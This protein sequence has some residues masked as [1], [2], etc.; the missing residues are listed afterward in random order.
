MLLFRGSPCRAAVN[1]RFQI[2]NLVPVLSLLGG[3]QEYC[4]STFNLVLSDCC[5]HS[6]VLLEQAEQTILHR[7][8]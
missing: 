4:K 3:L 1:P 6:S 7:W 8:G 2:S 5:A